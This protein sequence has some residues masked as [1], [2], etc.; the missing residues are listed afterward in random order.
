M[1]TSKYNLGDQ[2][3][4]VESN[5]SGTIIAVAFYQYIEEVQYFVRY[6]S[7]DGRLVE[8]WWGESAIKLKY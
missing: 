7:A 3:E 5:E 8:V 6:K 1:K 4:L 2:I